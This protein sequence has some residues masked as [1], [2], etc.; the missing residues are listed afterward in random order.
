MQHITS[1]VFNWIVRRTCRWNKSEKR[2]ET[3]NRDWWEK[4]ST[5]WRENELILRSSM[6]FRYE[7]LYSRTSYVCIFFFLSLI[8]L[9]FFCLLRASTLPAF[10]EN[11][12]KSATG[13]IFETRINLRFVMS[14]I[15]SYCLCISV[16][17]NIVIGTSGVFALRGFGPDLFREF[18]E[19][20]EYLYWICCKRMSNLYSRWLNVEFENSKHIIY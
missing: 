10:Y 18:N 3:N 17:I 12:F 13:C 11:I 20:W 6:C 1:G 16:V 9:R 7:G 2:E 14:D 19:N 5:W 4:H 15:D 8:L